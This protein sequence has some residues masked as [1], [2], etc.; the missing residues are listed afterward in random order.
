MSRPHGVGG[1]TR[2]SLPAGPA[3]GLP[4]VGPA[5]LTTPVDPAE[6]TAPPALYAAPPPG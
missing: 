1:C 5:G 4:D 6:P 2:K 3:A